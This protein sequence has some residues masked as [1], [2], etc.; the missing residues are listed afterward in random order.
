[1]CYEHRYFTL[2]ICVCSA[3]KISLSFLIMT[4]EI[5]K[6]ASSVCRYRCATFQGLNE[7]QNS[8]FL[9]TR[10]MHSAETKKS[11]SHHTGLLCCFRTAFNHHWPNS[12]RSIWA[13]IRHPHHGGPRP[14]CNTINRWLAGHLVGFIG[15]DKHRVCIRPFHRDSLASPVLVIKLS[16]RVIKTRG[17]ICLNARDR[18]TRP[19]FLVCH[20]PAN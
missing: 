6:Q 18:W 15:Q 1:M 10:P 20:I 11:V 19:A 3:V 13:L 9:Q 7:A 17:W 12:D 2:S 5:K 14:I 8:P 16:Q 4:E